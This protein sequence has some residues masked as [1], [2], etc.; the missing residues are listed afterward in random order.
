MCIGE[1]FENERWTDIF[2]VCPISVAVTFLQSN[3]PQIY[4]LM[5]G[6]NI[7]VL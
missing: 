2:L 1:D 4:P 6:S 7:V 5:A 3:S